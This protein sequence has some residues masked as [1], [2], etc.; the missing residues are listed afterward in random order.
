MDIPAVSD[1]D[2]LRRVVIRVHL[3]PT[4]L[5]LERLVVTIILVGERV[6]RV[7]NDRFVPRVV[8]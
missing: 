4:R 8:F 2:V 7:S 6:A 5:A 3:I 1:G